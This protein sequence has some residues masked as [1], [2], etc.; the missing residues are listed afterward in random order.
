MPIDR[1]DRHIPSRVG[2]I[3]GT[4]LG[5]LAWMV[6]IVGGPQAAPIPLEFEIDPTGPDWIDVR[7]EKVLR[8]E[9]AGIPHCEAMV[10]HQREL[11]RVRDTIRGIVATGRATRSRCQQESD[12]RSRQ[13]CLDSLNPLR[14]RV[15]DVV[16]VERRL[17][18]S[19]GRHASACNPAAYRAWE[20][21]EILRQSSDQSIDSG[22]GTCLDVAPPRPSYDRLV[23]IEIASVWSQ[24][25]KARERKR[26]DPKSTTRV[27]TAATTAFRERIKQYSKRKGASNPSA[28]T[29]F[30]MAVLDH[31][32]GR[33]TQALSRLRRIPARDSS[34][35]WKAPVAMLYGQILSNRSPDS[36]MAL[37]RTALPDSSLTAPAR[38][39]LGR[40]EL[41][42]ERFP[43]ALEHFSAY[44]ELPPAP[45]PGSRPQ[46]TGLAAHVLSEWILSWPQAPRTG[47]VREFLRDSLPRSARDTIALQVARNLQAASDA[48]NSI[49]I[50]SSFQVDYPGTKLG[51]EARSLLSR[52]RRKRN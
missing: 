5:F 13:A 26:L 8:R 21:L 12:A 42:N 43:K 48:R 6:L 33:E 7:L 15:A 24:E 44:L 18:D 9:D 14:R 28:Q 20:D 16:G 32:E 25:R 17:Q 51:D 22:F 47:S 29:H 4:W 31:R 52:L 2:G 23:E 46:A 34:T 36:A 27:D 40:I 37:L 19:V 30:L 38:F 3:R 50:L 49:E 39:L 41:E 1:P 10:A 35:V 45:A 11:A